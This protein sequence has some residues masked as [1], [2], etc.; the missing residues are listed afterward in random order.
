MYQLISGGIMV[1]CWVLSFF[2]VC[3]W[4]KTQER[5]FVIFSLAFAIMGFERF[6]L[7]FALGPYE[8]SPAFYL[9]RLSAF[10]LILIAIADKNRLRKR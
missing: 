10:L 2:F 1:A 3:F 7:G 5:L 9:I 6:L 4:R 8:A